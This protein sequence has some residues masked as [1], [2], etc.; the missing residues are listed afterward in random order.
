MLERLQQRES[1]GGEVSDVPGAGH[2]DRLKEE[3]Q[4]KTPE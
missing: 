3:G 4:K 1:G 2:P